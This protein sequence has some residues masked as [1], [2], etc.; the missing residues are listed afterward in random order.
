VSY[1]QKADRIAGALSH[2][3]HL[4][5]AERNTVEQLRAH[6]LGLPAKR[7]F[8]VPPPIERV[9][10][11][12]SLIDRMIQ[13]TSVSWRSSH[14]VLCPRYRRR[15]ETEYKKNLTAYA[16]WLRPT[17]RQRKHCLVYVH[18]WL[19]PGSWVEE[20]TL[21]RKWGRELEVDLLHVALP[22][23]GR[24]QPRS[25]LFSG[26]FFWTADLVRS[27]EGI[28]QAVC[29][30]R[31]AIAWLYRQGYESV[32]VTGISLGGAIDMLLACLEPLPDYVVPIVAH[33]QLEDAV[34]TAPILWRMKRDLERWGVDERSRRA[35]FRELGW[36]SYQPLLAPERQL[37]IQ[38]RDDGY[39]GAALV[40]QQWLAWRRPQIC[41]IEGGHMTFPL[42]INAIT[43][44]MRSFID[45]VRRS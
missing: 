28:R 16:R 44:A 22:F 34:E 24:R 11:A 14:G 7:M 40:E 12:H 26:E 19:E 4:R 21:F 45:E 33:L 31:A 15:H 20:A 43:R 3:L 6:Y 8:P 32:G 9:E 2:L 1:G 17:G 35:L 37:W 27:V 39:I 23:H 10:L 38:A 25:S 41:W 30:A 36:S 42:H 13:T 29:D 5:A 18:G